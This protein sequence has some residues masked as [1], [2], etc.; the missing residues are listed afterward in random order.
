[1]KNE[2][3]WR[4]IW[5][6]LGGTRTM[7]KA[8][9]RWLPREPAEEPAAYRVRLLRSFLFNMF[10][11]ALEKLSA[12]PFQQEVTIEPNKDVLPEPLEPLLSNTDLN[13]MDL[14]EFARKVFKDALKYGVTHVLVDTP[15]IDGLPPEAKLTIADEQ[16]L[17]IRPF[18]THVSPPS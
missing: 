1:M 6:I 18:F 16:R 9:K 13:G 3:E 11:D 12:K 4:L 17:D 10:G 8:G 7:R 15:V 5:D 2:A 14:T